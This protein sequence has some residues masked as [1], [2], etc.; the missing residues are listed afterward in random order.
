M[1][2]RWATEEE[3][4]HFGIPEWWG[5]ETEVLVAVDRKTTSCLG[6]IY[7]SRSTKQV[8]RMEIYDGRYDVE[9]RETLQKAAVQAMANG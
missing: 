2:T 3:R 8:E 9:I 7:F 5:H 4:R 1:L 6:Y